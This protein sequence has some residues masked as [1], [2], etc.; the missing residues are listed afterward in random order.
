MQYHLSGY[1]TPYQERIAQMEGAFHNITNAADAHLMALRSMYNTLLTQSSLYSFVD[2][3]RLFG[4]LCF[5][6]VP[7]VWLFRNVKPVG[8]PAAAH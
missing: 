5:A 1:E 3:F 2:N 8:K 4:F 7:L 6:C